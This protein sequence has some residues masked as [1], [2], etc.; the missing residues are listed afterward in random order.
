MSTKTRRPSSSPRK[1]HEHS[2]FTAGVS[3]PLA[4]P[5]C[6]PYGTPV[7]KP[8]PLEGIARTRYVSLRHFFCSFEKN[9]NPCVR[10]SFLRV[11]V[12]RILPIRRET[13]EASQPRLPSCGQVPRRGARLI[14]WLAR[15]SRVRAQHLQLGKILASLPART[16]SCPAHSTSPLT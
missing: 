10:D 13:T 6:L 3:D 9:R 7:S 4:D 12:D 11:R 16:R 2:V 15:T 5:P 14:A 8:T 1:T